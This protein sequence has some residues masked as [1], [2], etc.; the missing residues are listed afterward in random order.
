MNKDE[1]LRQKEVLQAELDKLEE[2]IKQEDKPT[3]YIPNMHEKYFYLDEDDDDAIFSLLSNEDF[4]NE[5]A[6]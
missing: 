5:L 4:L 2:L 1:L 6:S 3:C